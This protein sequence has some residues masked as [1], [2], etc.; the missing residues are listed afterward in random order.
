MVQEALRVPGRP[1][2]ASLSKWWLSWSEELMSQ[3]RASGAFL[4][5]G[6]H[7]KLCGRREWRQPMTQDPR[8]YTQAFWYPFYE[9][10][11]YKWVGVG[12][13]W[14]PILQFEN[15]TLAAEGRTVWMWAIVCS[16]SNRRAWHRPGM[17]AWT[18]AGALSEGA[19]DT[20]GL[21]WENKQLRSEMRYFLPRWT[22][23]P[24]H[25]SVS[26]TCDSSQEEPRA[27]SDHITVAADKS[28]YPLRSSRLENYCSCWACHEIGGP[29]AFIKKPIH[30]CDSTFKRILI[31]IFLRWLVSFV[32]LCILFH[33]FKSHSEKEP[34]GF[35]RLPKVS[36]AQ[37][38]WRA[39]VGE[40]GRPSELFRRSV[41]HGSD[42]LSED[43]ERHLTFLPVWFPR[44]GGRWRSSV[45]L[46]TEDTKSSQGH[47]WI[48]CKGFC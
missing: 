1:E 30:G 2:K 46:K 35:T 23:T 16:I 40:G 11:M 18:E 34:R 10:K 45:L 47:L 28:S 14:Q 26:S 41:W 38:K 31:T 9:Q 32:I 22:S 44:G 12:G 24:N 48:K 25:S 19:G 8:G 37:S 6:T 33:E 3:G 39:P 20:H 36:G 17:V 7:A 29:K 21:G 15:T 43:G 4:A 5:E 27:L 13:R 42:G